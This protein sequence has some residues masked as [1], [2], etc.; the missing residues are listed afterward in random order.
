[1]SDIFTHEK[2]DGHHDLWRRTIMKFYNRVLG[3]RDY[4]LFEVVRTGLRLPPILSSFGTVE[5]LSLSSWRT[6]RRP[7]AT[8]GIDKDDELVVSANKVDVFNLRATLPRPPSI[9]DMDLADLSFYAFYRQFYYHQKKLHRR[10]QE[11]FVS[12]SGTGFPAQAARSHADH[13]FY[14]QRILYAYMPCSGLA[15]FEYIDAVVARDFDGSYR[16]ALR[17]FVC[18]ACNL[19]CPTWIRRNYEYLND[20]EPDASNNDVGGN[21]TKP[22]PSAATKSDDAARSPQSSRKR[23]R[24][25]FTFNEEHLD[26]EP[27]I[28]DAEDQATTL[29]HWQGPR[30]ASLGAT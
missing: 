26:G 21:D 24:T 15:G 18:D 10:R 8:S 14:A 20:T 6:L 22:M 23:R 28:N 29:D 12:V 30:R 2:E 11:K 27:P 1:M 4:T 16:E 3:D 9:T 19:W 7:A 17:S 5:N 13:D 25:Q